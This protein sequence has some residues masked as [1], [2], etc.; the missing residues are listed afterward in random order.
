MCKENI[1]E[2]DLQAIKRIFIDYPKVYK[3]K[4]RELIKAEQER[5]DLLHVLELGRLNAVQQSKITR[6]LK[7]VSVKR[8]QIKNNLEILEVVNKFA[9]S[10]NNNSNKN[11]Q[12]ETVTNT[13]SNIM[14]RE[15]TYTMRVRT[16]LQKLLGVKK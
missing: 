1:I 13:V 7:A 4:K 2:N 10:F 3:T 14:A 5:Q 9:N 11:N 8:R 15:R 12:I 6:D 16:D